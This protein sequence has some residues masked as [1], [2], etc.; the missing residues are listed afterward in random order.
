MNIKELADKYNLDANDFWEFPQKKGMWILTH[1]AIEKIMSQENIE[2]TEWDT[3]NSEHDL[4][5]FKITMSMP[6]GSGDVK[7][8]TTIGEADRNNCR[9]QYLGCIAEKRGIDR[10]VLKIINAYEYSVFSEIESDDF[11]NKNVE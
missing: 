4:V 6:L 11:K 10:G 9:T 3:L 5:R 2:V 8:V 7:T 1:D